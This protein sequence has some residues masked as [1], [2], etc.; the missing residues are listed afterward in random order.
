MQPLRKTLDIRKHRNSH[1][2][3]GST[4]YESKKLNPF[5]TKKLSV[6]IPNEKI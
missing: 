6:N 5:K 2:I 3:G 4:M 1:S